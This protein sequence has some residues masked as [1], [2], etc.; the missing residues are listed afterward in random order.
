M[1]KQDKVLF[2]VPEKH[3]D[4]YAKAIEKL[5]NDAMTSI[6][7]RL[8]EVELLGIISRNAEEGSSAV[9]FLARSG[10]DPYEVLAIIL[11]G[12]VVGQ[13]NFNVE[14]DGYLLAN[15]IV[16]DSSVTFPTLCIPS[17]EL[18]WL[19]KPT[20]WKAVRTAYAGLLR[21][22]RKSIERGAP[23]TWAARGQI[24]WN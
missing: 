15:T 24:K 8:D 11:C 17:L 18:G 12:E 1:G 13:F 7:K 2:L 4:A 23:Y 3:N 16:P 5:T 9:N 21:N 22:G 19:W 6:G 14:D 20:Q 10:V